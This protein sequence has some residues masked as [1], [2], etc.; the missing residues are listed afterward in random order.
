MVDLREDANPRR[1][2]PSI[3]MASAAFE[4]EMPTDR[5]AGGEDRKRRQAPSMRWQARRPYLYYPATIRA[6]VTTAVGCGS[7]PMIL[8]ELLFGLM[9]AGMVLLVLP[10]LLFMAGVAG[11]V[12]LAILAPAALV[13]L[14]IFWL[15]FPGAHGLALLLLVLVIGLILVEQRSRRRMV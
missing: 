8:I 7:F 14:L 2:G 4:P 6:A 13:A 3:S 5:R 9:L 15:V 1:S 11:A 12:L 10:F